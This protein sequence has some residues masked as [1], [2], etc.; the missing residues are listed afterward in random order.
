MRLCS[1]AVLIEP[2]DRVCAVRV[3]CGFLLDWGALRAGRFFESDLS[4]L[5]EWNRLVLFADELL[6]ECIL[7][8]GTFIY[9]CVEW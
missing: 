7:V 4:G 9:C 6:D 1:D 5:S 8:T 3:T 2:P